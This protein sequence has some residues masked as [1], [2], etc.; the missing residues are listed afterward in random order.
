MLLL[1][2]PTAALAQIAS[3]TSHSGFPAPLDLARDPSTLTEPRHTPLL[4][5]Y[6]WTAGDVTALLPDRSKFPPQDQTLRI[7]PHYFRK[8]FTVARAPRAAVLYLAGPRSARVWINGDL[9]ASFSRDIDQ[10]LGVHVFS[11]EVGRALR[12]G[13]N[14]IA[15]EAV[16]GRGIG[17]AGS[18]A[19]ISQQSYGE[20]LVVKILAR[21]PGSFQADTVGHA[22]LISDTTWKSSAAAVSGWQQPKF[23]DSS[24]QRVESLGPIE[25]NPDFFQWNDDAGLYDWPGYLGMSPS[26]RT[27]KVRAVS[28]THLYAGGGQ[29][30]NVAAL[31]PSGGEFGVT[32]PVASADPADPPHLLLD[33]GREIAGRLYVESACDCEEEIS[34]SYG[35][36][37]GEALSGQ[38]FLGVNPLRIGPHQIARG[39]KSAFRYAYIRFLGSAPPAGSREP[40]N[41]SPELRFRVLRAE[42]IAYPVTYRGSFE[43]SDPLLNRIWLTSAY[44]VHLCMQDSIWDAPK[45]DRG[46]W[47]GDLTIEGSVISDVFGDR[48][49]LEDTLAHLAANTRGGTL[50]VNGIPGYTAAWVE[51]LADLYQHTGDMEFL[52]RESGIL[53]ALLAHME[54]GLDANGH[55]IKSD[56]GWFFV[57]WS[58]G[59][60]GRT[61]EAEYGTAMEYVR[62][63]HAAVPLL[64]ALGDT[65]SAAHYQQYAEG[66]AEALRR[67]AIGSGSPQADFG[68][69]WQIN[70]LAVLSGV[71]RPADDAAIWNGVLSHVKQDAWSDQTITP[72]FNFFVLEAMAQMGHREAALQWIRQYWGGMLAEGATSFWEAYDLRWPKDQPHLSLQADNTSGYRTSL[73]HGWSAGPAAWLQEEL[74]G[75]RPTAPGFRTVEIRPDLMGLAWARGAMPTPTGII[76]IGL[77]KEA[78]GTT[79]T[80]DLPRSETAHVLV[81]VTQGSH[82][83]F[84]N[85]HPHSTGQ[86]PEALRRDLVL[87]QPGHY[88]IESR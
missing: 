17:H 13:S 52:K 18:N 72:Y 22:L 64:R 33:F 88:V 84:V 61:P 86:S 71:A 36:S 32:L 47:A 78:G 46:R 67:E 57:D 25:G 9:V 8:T 82:A 12:T 56:Q 5:Q 2:F 53:H 39:P 58:P 37:I 27:Y 60:N 29:F 43:S 38:Q 49:A 10:P 23:D 45:R 50:D 30:E 80:L 24:W 20:V 34:V 16:R 70:A 68:P 35:E 51:A 77:K 54:R 66:L 11:A 19:L 75:I 14:T 41:P 31:G 79:I 44:T 83:I 21:P 59:L 7:A 15:I 6:I 85:G 55:F 62:G 26:L 65:A 42:G 48:P 3:A 1:L 4:E 87:D 40:I 74:L 63:F 73:A 81:P 76:R 28:V 69:R